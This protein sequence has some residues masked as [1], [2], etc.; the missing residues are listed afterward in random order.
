[1][2][3]IIRN[4]LADY[5]YNVVA[6]PKADLAPLILLSEESG[7]VS[8]LDS[9]ITDLFTAT[10]GAV[11]EVIRNVQ[12]SAVEGAASVQYEAD[13]GVSVLDWLM[14]KLHLG[15]LEGKLTFDGHKILHLSYEKVLEDK[16]NLVKLDYFITGS[17]PA[18]AEF[19]TFRPRLENSELYVISS[20][21]KSNSFTVTVE[22]ANGAQVDIAASIKG[23]L[24]ATQN[25]T[26][27]GKNSISIK[28][29]SAVPLVF[30][31]KAQQ[32]IYNKKEWWQ[33]FKKEIA[34]FT[35]RNKEGIIMRGDNA[36]PTVSLAAD[37][38]S[39]IAL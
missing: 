9:P 27:S 31:F 17:A 24:G 23:I 13:A 38:Y 16:V 37:K 22:D 33:F 10:Q 36:Y 12:A 29:D 6:L 34:G 32:I 21:L 15:K 5:G 1:M 30:A 14:A 25:I 26:T 2:N 39:S 35:I 20:V 19:N 8:S 4:F 3:K 7:S 18:A 11:P 28:N